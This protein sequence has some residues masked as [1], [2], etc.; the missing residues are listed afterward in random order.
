MLLIGS[1]LKRQSANAPIAHTDTT[2]LE[3]SAQERGDRIVQFH[4]HVVRLVNSDKAPTN[5][6]SLRRATP[7]PASP[8]SGLTKIADFSAN[9]QNVLPKVKLFPLEGKT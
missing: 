7:L 4:D 8:S 5:T 2:L 9:D 6:H 1:A 3:A